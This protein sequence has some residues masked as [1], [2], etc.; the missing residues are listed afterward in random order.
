MTTD[1]WKH[2]LYNNQNIPFLF[3]KDIYEYDMKDAG[4]S[5]IREFEQLPKYKIKELE[6]VTDKHERKVR[7][8]KIE[9]SDERFKKLHSESF[10]LARKLFIDA[11]NLDEA[12]II[13]IKKD[14]IITSCYCAKQKVGSYINFREKQNYTS[15]IRLDKRLEFY[16]NPYKL[17]VKGMS[18]ENLEKHRE[19][20]LKFLNLF[21]RQMETESETEVLDFL[22]QF[23][24]KYKRKELEVGY[25]RSFDHRSSFQL[26]SG[27]S[28][29]TEYWEDE[30]NDL[31]IMY[32]FNNILL[33][34]VKI[35]L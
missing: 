7:I 27:E 15:Y 18:D 33:K 4:F 8:G 1:I 30:K 14:A 9:R 24:D 16:Y 17:D 5:L 26:L 21:F 22:R 31:D 28:E 3:N 29:F 2:D 11:N 13:A 12:N 23:I 34:L 35:L 25:Y 20:V 19:Y 6:K 10:S 32:N